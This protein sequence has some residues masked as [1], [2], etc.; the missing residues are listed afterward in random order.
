MQHLLSRN[1]GIVC[2]PE[3]L[4]PEL[5]KKNQNMNKKEYIAPACEVI[6][7]E[8]NVSMMAA[9]NNDRPVTP[10]EDENIELNSNRHRGEWGNQGHESRTRRECVAGDPHPVTPPPRA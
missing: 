7:M 10:G 1:S 6:E 8:T 5:L 9:S 4:T 3:L 2:T